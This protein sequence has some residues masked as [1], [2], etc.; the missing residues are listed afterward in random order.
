MTTPT[1]SIQ[2][3]LQRAQAQTQANRS[4]FLRKAADGKLVKSIATSK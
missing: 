1:P 3:L 4:L 2:A